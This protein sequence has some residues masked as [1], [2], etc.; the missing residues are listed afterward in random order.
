MTK[1]VRVENA[2]TSNHKLRV[3]IEDRQIDGNWVRDE[4]VPLE[5]PTQLLSI[6]VH[7][8]RRIVV[9]EVTE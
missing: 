2:D 7:I 5:A 4:G 3:F 8:H 6:H 9:E 1:L